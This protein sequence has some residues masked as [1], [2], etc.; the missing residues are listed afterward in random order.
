[1]QEI[2]SMKEDSVW[3]VAL[4]VLAVL[5]LAAVVLIIRLCVQLKKQSAAIE[6]Y[7]KESKRTHE[8][9]Q[10]GGEAADDSFARFF[11]RK[12]LDKVMQKQPD[13]ELLFTQSRMKSVNMFINS[14]GFSRMI[15]AM[16]AESLFAFLN[17]MTAQTIPLIYQSGGMVERFEELGMNVYFENLGKEALVCAISVCTHLEELRD[18]EK[19]EYYNNYSIGICLDNTLAGVVGDINR[20]S[21]LSFSAE[22]PGFARW[23]QEIALD[24]YAKIVVTE[25]YLNQLPDAK[26]QFHIRK[27]GAVWIRGMQCI[28]VLYDVYDGDSAQVRNMK[29]QTRMLF[30]EGV[31]LYA[32][33]RFEDARRHFVEVVK[34]DENDVAARRYIRLCEQNNNS[35]QMFHDVQCFEIF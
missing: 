30:E 17:R 3:L 7:Q 27:L 20:A 34:A 16:T 33:G 18:R 8:Q 4:V 32:K 22:T 19:N 23:L 15:H 26:R 13:G 6:R 14:S 21:I 11:P 24:Y 9:M 2:G 29:R 25:E 1:M 5:L 28:Q 31:E 12:I 10:M 35:R